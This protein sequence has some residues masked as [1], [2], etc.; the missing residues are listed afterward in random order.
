MKYLVALIIA[1]SAFVAQAQ[2]KIVASPSRQSDVTYD[3]GPV[4]SGVAVTT[5]TMDVGGFRSVNCQFRNPDGASRSV[6]PLCK[7]SR[8][9][10]MFTYPTTTVTSGSSAFIAWGDA[11]FDPDLYPST[12][13]LNTTAA[14]GLPTGATYYPGSPCRW[15]SVGSAA[16]SGVAQVVCTLKSH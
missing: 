11:V 16:A 10:T 1:A 2:T 8:G 7:D 4:T 14:N 6:I 9:N 3:P 13:V 12:G 15:L 5:G